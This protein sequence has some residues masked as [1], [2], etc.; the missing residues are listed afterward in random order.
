M[1]ATVNLY[2]EQKGEINKFLSKLYDTDIEIPNCL[3]WEKEFKNPIEISE[4]IGI[5]IDNI[6][7]YSISMFISLDKNVFINITEKNGDSIIEYL[8]ERYPY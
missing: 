7:D 3:K 5:F 1:I 4:L 2:S 6:D 8:F